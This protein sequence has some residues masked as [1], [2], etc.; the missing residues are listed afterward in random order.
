MERE[1][2]NMRIVIPKKPAELI[3]LGKAIGA[4]HLALGANSPLKDIE[5]IGDL[6]GLAATAETNH[7]NGKSLLDQ[8]ET[9]NQ[10]R[11]TVLGQKGKLRVGTV[12]HLVTATRSVL[13]GQNKGQEHKLANW[14]FGVIDA[15][16]TTSNP[17][18]AAAKAAKKATKVTRIAAKAAAKVKPA[19]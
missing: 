2:T 16:S 4:K 7:N 18:K 17:A 12:R 6:A 15:A 3:V 1:L 11:E 19:A 5:G 10:A 13:S 8:A 9:A 14:G